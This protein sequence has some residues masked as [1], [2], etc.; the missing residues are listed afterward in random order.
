MPTMKKLNIL[1]S[2]VARPTR[3]AAVA[4]L[5]CGV[6]V[7]ALA[8]YKIVGPDGKITYTDKPPTAQDIKPEIGR[9]HV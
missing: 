9:A 4:M 3:L 1:S 5:L 8:Q 7:G 6:T 2:A